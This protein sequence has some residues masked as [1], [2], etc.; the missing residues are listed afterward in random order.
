MRLVWWIA[1][2]AAFAG[3]IFAI[4]DAIINRLW[5]DH[6]DPVIDEMPKATRTRCLLGVL[7]VTNTL[8]GLFVLADHMLGDKAAGRDWSRV[9]RKARGPPSPSR[10]TS[11]ERGRCGDAVHGAHD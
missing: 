2:V 3:V 9:R 8:T 7:V 10:R 6:V 5:A 11:A 4:N 1:V